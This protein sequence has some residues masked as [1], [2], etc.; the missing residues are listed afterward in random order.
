MG[1]LQLGQKPWSDVWQCSW[2]TQARERRGL[3]V[4][5]RRVGLLWQREGPVRQE[6]LTV[7]F[8]VELGECA[9]LKT[10]A[11]RRFPARRFHQGFNQRAYWS[12]RRS[13]RR[14]G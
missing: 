14:G 2:S 4:S 10:V 11:L 1:G 6:V 7:F 9:L 12:T 8:Q 13:G 5:L 3:Q